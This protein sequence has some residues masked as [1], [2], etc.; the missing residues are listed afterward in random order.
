MNKLIK[1]TSIPG[2]KSDFSKQYLQRIKTESH[3][4]TRTNP[5]KSHISKT[6]RE[7]QPGE[8]NIDEHLEHVIFLK[9]HG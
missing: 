8:Y 5:S 6:I 1:Y 9:S 3:P 2:K 7:I 4:P